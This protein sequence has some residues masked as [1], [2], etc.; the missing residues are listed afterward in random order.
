MSSENIFQNVKS[1]R[2]SDTVVDQILSLIEE[3]LLKIGDRLP[4]E[5]ELVEQLGVG[6][7]SVREALRILEAQGVL[8]VRP[9][10]G[11]FI[12]G[13]PAD[14]TAGIEGI[15]RWFQDHADEILEML[16]VRSALERQAANLA[17]RRANTA[18]IEGLNRILEEAQRY[19]AEG[20]FQKAGYLDHEFHRELANASGNKML[21]QLIDSTIEALISP[22]RSIQQLPG[23]AELSMRE[24]RQIV[25]AIAREDPEAAEAA[26]EK[27]IASVRQ[28]ILALTTSQEPDQ[29]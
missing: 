8:E 14:I 3:G 19:V 10:R 13:K 18:Q 11:A 21:T 6:R 7:A 20:N 4:G 15:R 23:R 29:S 25:N 16:E 27:H 2:L 17:A 5:R 22:R 24:H 12:T 9:G 1:V 28:A 26:V